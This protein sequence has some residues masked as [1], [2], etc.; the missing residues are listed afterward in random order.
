MEG[1]SVE[2]TEIKPGV[3]IGAGDTDSVG[4]VGVEVGEGVKRL[5]QPAVGEDDVVFEH[6][7]VRRLC[8]VQTLLEDMDVVTVDI[9][10]S[11]YSTN[12][13]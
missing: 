5:D 3:W 7:D 2:E 10:V 13:K 12:K 9:R 4:W 1:L 6:G 8:A 11:T